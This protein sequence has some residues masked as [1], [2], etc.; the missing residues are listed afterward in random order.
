M[1]PELPPNLFENKVIFLSGGGSGVNLAI[2]RTLA[3][4]G[5]DLAICGRSAERLEA[6]ATELRGLGARVVAKTADV[7]DLEAVQAVFDASQ[8]AL[9]PVDGVVC[10]A[11]GNFMAP[12]EKLSA[13]GFRSVV[14]IDLIGTFNCARAAYDQLAETQGS[15]LFVSG[16]QSYMAFA[17]QA[18]VSAAKAGVDQL[19]RTLALEWADRGIRVNSIVPGPVLD[20][21]GMRRLTAGASSQAWIDSVPLGRFAEPEEIGRV[22][23]FLLSPWSSYITGAQVV[24][25]GGLTLS[26]AGLINR[27]TQLPPTE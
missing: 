20:T 14:E 3:R 7:R 9:G 17:H 16:G 4:S 23:A 8:D 13:N 5:A 18:H 22:A 2:A 25:D 27:G 15:M 6:A 24:A 26:G 12:A 11:A 19:M 10:G 21:E 1:A